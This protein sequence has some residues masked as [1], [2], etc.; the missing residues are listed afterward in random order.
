MEIV[1]ISFGIKEYD[2]RL[3]ELVRM[4]SNI[5]RVKLLCCSISQDPCFYMTSQQQYL[6]RKN[7]LGFIGYVLRNCYRIKQTDILVCDNLFAAF[8]T[9]LVRRILKP[10]FLLQD[11]RELYFYKEQHGSGKFFSFFESRLIRKADIVLAANQERAQIMQ[12]EYHLETPPLVFENFRF[13][14]GEYDAEKMKEKY[15]GVFRYAFNIISTSGLYMERESDKL[16][17]AMKKC[18]EG[19]GLFFVGQSSEKEI[20]KYK[21]ICAE[22]GIHNVHLI[23]KVPMNELRYIVQQCQIGVVHYHMRNR[24]NTYCASGKVYE[25]LHEG[26]PVVTTEN[27]PLKAFCEISGTGIADRDF[28]KGISGIIDQYEAYQARVKE[29]M[30]GRTPEKYNREVAQAIMSRLAI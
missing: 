19:C 25:F 8:P 6:S 5:G 3:K 17:R 4:L 24:N 15:A 27:P 1:I 20:E 18:P 11:V 16:I 26:L 12:E 7:Y 22:E 10:R 23:G 30:E 14:D 29:Y 9:L 13:L 21:K 28:Y 2:G